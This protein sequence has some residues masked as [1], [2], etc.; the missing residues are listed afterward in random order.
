MNNGRAYLIDG[1]LPHVHIKVVKHL[2]Q[3]GRYKEARKILQAF[4]KTKASSP[5][6]FVLLS[7]VSGMFGDQEPRADEGAMSID[8]ALLKFVSHTSLSSLTE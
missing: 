6:D 4:V 7:D 1:T 3:N 5:L 2:M 8:D